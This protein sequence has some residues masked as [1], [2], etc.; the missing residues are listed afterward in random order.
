MGSQL[1]LTSSNSVCR[2]SSGETCPLKL[3]V[4]QAFSTLSVCV[5]LSV[6]FKKNKEEWV[7]IWPLLQDVLDELQSILNIANSKCVRAKVLEKTLCEC[8]FYYIY[9]RLYFWS[10]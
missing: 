3:D 6:E 2:S 8:Y 4:V 9:M 1:L 5:S 10:Q 7:E